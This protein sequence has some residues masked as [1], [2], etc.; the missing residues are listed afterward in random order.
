MKLAPQTDKPTPAA[1][2]GDHPNEPAAKPADHAK[3]ALQQQS[4]ELRTK[5]G[6]DAAKPQPQK[7]DVS[8]VSARLGLT[9]KP[10]DLNI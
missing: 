9:I 8:E 1:P 3:D 2:K 5:P 4:L 7:V 6:A 10:N